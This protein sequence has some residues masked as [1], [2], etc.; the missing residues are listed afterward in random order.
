MA[1]KDEVIEGAA[2]RRF[3]VLE[4]RLERAEANLEIAALA[5]RYARAADARDIEGL[6]TLYVDDVDC[7]SFGRGPEALRRQFSTVLR[8]FY[9]SVHFVCGQAVDDLTEESASGTTY[10]LAMQELSTGWISVAVRYEDRYACQAGSWRFVRRVPRTWYVA[11]A[12]DGRVD[13]REVWPGMRFHRSIPDSL[14]TWR[15]F[16]G[17]Q[18][19]ADEVP[20]R[21][22]TT[23][24]GT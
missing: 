15:A 3:E 20:Q 12:H 23:G 16:W 1:N 24:S 6:V 22:T 8:D 14:E 10:C 17:A 18:A 21:P 4:R 2:R 13:P 19:L 9:R 7:G 5:A 11:P